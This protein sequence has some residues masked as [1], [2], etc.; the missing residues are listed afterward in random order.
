MKNLLRLGLSVVLL[1]ALAAV[2]GMAEEPEDGTADPEEET[3]EPIDYSLFLKGEEQVGELEIPDTW[4]NGYRRMTEDEPTDSSSKG[5]WVT[6]YVAG[7]NTNCSGNGLVPT[8]EGWFEG[9][10][11]DDVTVVLHALSAPGAELVVRLFADVGPNLCN[12]SFVPPIASETVAVEAGEDEIEV[13]FEGLDVTVR[14]NLVLMVTAG[15]DTTQSRLSFDSTAAPSRVELRCVPL[16][17]LE[18]CLY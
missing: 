5:I 16:E 12:E 17:G 8:W 14:D 10:L 11:T 7:P 6:N 15:T 2:P 1:L 13:V 3:V 9:T 4:L 18:T